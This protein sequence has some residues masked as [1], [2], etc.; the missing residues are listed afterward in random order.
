V[1]CRNTQNIHQMVVQFYE[2][3]VSPAAR[4]PVGRP[5]GVVFYDNPQRLRSTLQAVL[6]RLTVDEQI[7]T[8]EIVVLTP[9]SLSKS[10]LLGGGT[11]GGPE[12]TDTW[13]PLPGH[14][15]W[16]TIYDFKGLER[17]VVILADIH[18]WPPEWDEMIKLLYVGCSRARNHLLVL[19][20][21]NARPK[22]QRAFAVAS[23]GNKAR[24]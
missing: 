11:S 13:P 12:L 9:R 18:R 17:A 2:A 7:P 23:S 3:E 1:N 22:M 24:R 6:R 4:G 8:D 5:V 21:Q 16:T 20:P 19:L 15:Y 10:R 14:V